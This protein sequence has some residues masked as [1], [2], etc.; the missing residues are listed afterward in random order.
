MTIQQL[1]P[2][3]AT[4]DLDQVLARLRAARAEHRL[5]SFA[6]PIKKF[7]TVLSRALLNH[8][9]VR[10]H[11]QLV[12]LGY[13]LR[14][15]AL[16]ALEEH[17]R[18]VAPSGEIAVPRGVVFHLP[19]A[20]VDTLFVYSWLLS[21]AVGNAN[22]IRLPEETTPAVDLLLKQV[23]QALAEAGLEAHD[24]IVTYPRDDRITGALSELVDVRCVWGGDAKVRHIHAL[25]L[26]PHAIE[27]GFAD[28][29][30]MAALQSHAVLDLAP[31]QRRALAEKFYNDVFWFNQMGCASPRIVFWVGP[32]ELGQAA[33]ATFFEA[34]SEVIEAKDYRIELG[35]V[36]EKLGYA[37]RSILD[38]PVTRF[39]FHRNELCVLSLDEAA[40][41]RE[42]VF[43]AGTLMQV[44]LERLP[45]LAGF[46]VRKDQ[47]LTHFGFGPDEIDIL[48]GA[49]NG[50][51]IDRIVP[52][53]RALDFHHVWDGM[54]LLRQF[55]RLVHVER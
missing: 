47:T 8:P 31:E 21:L 24:M 53:G 22:L 25:P 46:V 30:S 35:T 1:L 37:Y 28:R 40:D 29:F 23:G 2:V 39:E 45:A 20:N 41:F 14:P 11:P 51:G 7:C 9:D 10:Q 13:W 54:D 38:L 18:T 49:L 6:E 42:T 17:F 12:A 15:A 52:V 55:S 16:K 32:P 3:R 36:L 34:L 50:R 26:S 27:I 44:T 5:T 4:L 48:V 43:G 33:S 19:P